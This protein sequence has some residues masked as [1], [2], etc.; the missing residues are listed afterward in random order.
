MYR[1]WFSPGLV[2]I[3]MDNVPAHSQLSNK[4]TRQHRHEIAHVHRHDRQH[5]VDIQL[6]LGCAERGPEHAVVS[7]K[8]DIQ[9][10]AHTRDDKSQTR[11]REVN[12]KPPWLRFCCDLAHNSDRLL[13]ALTCEDPG[14]DHAAAAAAV[15]VAVWFHIAKARFRLLARDNHISL[16]KC[17]G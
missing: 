9:K 15:V 7:E 14:L 10:I 13:D 3:P 5:A 1:T 2:L 17:D 4:H 8:G 12:A 11:A 6:A 16:V